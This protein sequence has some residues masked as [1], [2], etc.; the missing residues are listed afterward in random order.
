MIFLCE[1]LQPLQTNT[2][3]ALTYKMMGNYK[4]LKNLY[5]NNNFLKV[6]FEIILEN[7]ML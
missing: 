4:G 3:S 5:N 2:L 6:L 1:T 7:L